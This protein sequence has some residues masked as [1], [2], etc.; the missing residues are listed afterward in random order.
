MYFQM[1]KDILNKY[2]ENERVSV[3]QA[4]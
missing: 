1:S 2:D 4:F 3:K